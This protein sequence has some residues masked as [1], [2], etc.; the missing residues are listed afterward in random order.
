MKRYLTAHS[1]NTAFAFLAAACGML[2]VFANIKD[3][4]AYTI[5]LIGNEKPILFFIICVALGAAVL[6]NLLILF[7][8][9]GIKSA[10][11]HTAA[12]AVNLAMTVV[13]LTVTAH[14][15][16]GITELHWLCALLFMAGNPVL[17]L[18]CMI[19]KSRSGRRN[20]RGTFMIFA[21]LYVFD[22]LYVFRSFA[23]FGLMDGKNGIMELIPIFS[24]IVLLMILN[25]SGE[26]PVRGCNGLFD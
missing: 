20:I 12:Y 8:K 7:R 10:L 16:Q 3:P 4:Q 14:Y 6:M 23:L 5:S 2:F 17:I 9:C 25:R 21:S 13:P 26:W 22:L 18:L 1:E 19:K 24:T 11:V 15:V